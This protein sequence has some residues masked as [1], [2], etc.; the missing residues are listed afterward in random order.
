MDYIIVKIIKMGSPVNSYSLEP[1]STVEDLFNVADIEF[2]D[3]GVTLRGQQVCENTVLSDGD[4]IIVADVVKGN[5]DP[6]EVEIFRL[7]GGR[8]VTLPAQDGMSI[9]TVLE[10]LNPEEK[11]QF[12]RSNGQPAYEFRISGVNEAVTIDTVV[13]RPSSGKVR[14]IASQVVKGNSVKVM[15]A[16]EDY[17]YCEYDSIAA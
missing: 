4:S 8:S 16:A 1:G 14:V 17:S 11:A 2:K 5:L 6:F 3:G 13:Q 12:F 10:Q 15:I 7:G 9:K